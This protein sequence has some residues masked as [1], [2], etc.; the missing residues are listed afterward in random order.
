M[1]VGIRRNLRL[2]NKK[3]KMGLISLGCAKNLVDSE[4]ILGFFEQADFTR[5]T[6]PEEA[7][8]LVVNTCGFIEAAKQESIDAILEMAQYKDRGRCRV[9][10]VAGCLS[11]RYA[12]EL[13]QEIPEID[14][15][16]GVA[17]YPLLPDLVKKALNGGKHSLVQQ[18]GFIYNEN[19]PRVLATPPFMA[20]VKIAEG[21]ANR[22]SYCAIPLIRGPL[23]SRPI[24][25]ITAEVRQLCAKGVAEINVIAQD[26]T[27]YGLDLYGKPSLA[28]LLEQLVAI[29]DVQWL[30][31]LYAY[32]NLIDDRLL[33]VF[34][35]HPQICR[36]LD[37]PLQHADSE[38]L[39]AMR[40]RGRPEQYLDLLGKIR[41]A[42]P[43]IALRSSF[44]VGFPGETEQQF[45]TLL[46]F[47]AE[48]AFD[49]AGVF[50]YSAEENTPAAD[51]P[52]QV[53]GTV[54]EERY[55]RAMRQQAAITRKALA[56]RI[57]SESAF[58]CTGQRQQNGDNLI[59]GRVEWQAPDVDGI[60]LLEGS[61]VKSGEL[62]NVKITGS[63]DYDLRAARA[64]ENPK[65]E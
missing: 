54:K 45:Q 53:S 51:L 21:C 40:R 60:T 15:L 27:A 46:D 5:T 42:V 50:Q 34:A 18:C 7:D 65:K 31:V 47:M 3:L 44:I 48:A 56:G 11:R 35:T 16:V 20:Y 58:L 28:D 59:T 62:I 2:Q 41:A 1:I 25:S 33:E 43:G 63:G 55:H 38:L 29:P 64:N 23:N 32:P 14:V 61:R 19:M 49:Y 24:A 57:G 22:C 52:G 26:T 39:S 4:V 8:I 37:L 12:D 10:A 6:N 30:R 17:E 13:T 9:L 36:Y